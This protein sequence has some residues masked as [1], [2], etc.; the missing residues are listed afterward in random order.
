MLPAVGQR[1]VPDAPSLPEAAS[2]PAWEPGQW[3]RGLCDSRQGG[4]SP[5]AT[6]CPPGAGGQ[7]ARP[8]PRGRSLAGR[9]FPG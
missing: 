4:S 2:C 7:K 9:F 1:G 6:V 5:T 3:R 8:G